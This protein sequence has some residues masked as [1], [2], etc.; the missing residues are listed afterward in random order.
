MSIQVVADSNVTNKKRRTCNEQ[1][2]L[3][4][5][6]VGTGRME[7]RRGKRFKVVRKNP[8]CPSNSSNFKGETIGF[9]G[10]DAT[11]LWDPAEI[12]WD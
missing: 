10:C 3:G 8:N 1:K 9:L 5:E 12:G 2:G 7:R 4:L 11:L 6:T